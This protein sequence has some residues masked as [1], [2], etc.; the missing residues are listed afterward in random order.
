MG[1][2]VATEV[3]RLKGGV[4]GAEELHGSGLAIAVGAF[5]TKV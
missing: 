1:V 4:L 5:T 2:S 3:R